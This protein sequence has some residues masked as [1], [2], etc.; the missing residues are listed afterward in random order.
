ME[1]GWQDF[2]QWMGIGGA[3][4]G[5]M[6]SLGRKSQQITDLEV[7]MAK[8]E[9]AAR[10]ALE[11]TV[12]NGHTLSELKATTAMTFDL[13]KEVRDDIRKERH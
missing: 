11:K 4:G 12:E 1:Q 3:G 6:F 9:E 5:A 7:R 2:L 8:V 10:V 13:V